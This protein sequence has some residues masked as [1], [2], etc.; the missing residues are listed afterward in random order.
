M[1]NYSRDTY[2]LNK[3]KNYVGVRLQ[4]GVPLVDADWNEMD[5][6]R[7][8]EIQSFL[9]NYVGDGTPGGDENFRIV[10]VAAD[11]DF[12]IMGGTQ[13]APGRCLVD[14]WET[15]IFGSVDYS[16]QPLYE[17]PTLAAEWGVDKVDALS[18][19]GTGDRT[20][21]VYLDIWEREVG[22]AE[23]TDLVNPVIGVETCT[24][25]KREW[26]VRVA[27]N[28][29]EPPAPS[30][31]HAFYALAELERSAGV[32]AIVQ[33]KINER[34]QVGFKTFSELQ[35]LITSGTSNIGN[36]HVQGNLGVGTPTPQ[37]ELEVDGAIVG[38]TILARTVRASRF[39]VNGV[40]LISAEAA[41]AEIDALKAIVT[42]L[43][44]RITILEGN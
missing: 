39:L 40:E 21:L 6:I 14:G 38:E 3:S 12:T 26:T 15:L 11:N 25:L 42:D 43:E 32:D 34:R 13:D 2:E 17:N 18:A 23:D 28:A 1:G 16:A 31:G 19:P 5:D 30:E 8:R 20:D 10:Q 35:Q 24:R 41:Q 36:F 27:E 4:Q 44:N 22:Y 37:W 33:D 29:T 7:K 9:K